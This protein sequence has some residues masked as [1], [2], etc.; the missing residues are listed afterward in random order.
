MAVAEGLAETR[1]GSGYFS[2]PR[3]IGGSY[4]TTVTMEGLHVTYSIHD[5]PNHA[6]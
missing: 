6:V 4:I 2:R 5:I 3:E 1:T